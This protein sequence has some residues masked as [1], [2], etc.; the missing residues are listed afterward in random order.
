MN[1]LQDL[2][3]YEAESKSVE[4]NDVYSVSW[5]PSLPSIFLIFNSSSWQVRFCKIIFEVKEI[6]VDY[7]IQS[8]I[9]PDKVSANSVRIFLSGKSEKLYHVGR[10]MISVADITLFHHFPFFIPSSLFESFIY[11]ARIRFPGISTD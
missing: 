5:H 11:V 8:E 2:P 7:G 4:I 10:Y 6:T 3:I 9:L 1:I